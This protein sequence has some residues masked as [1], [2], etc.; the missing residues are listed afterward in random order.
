MG[1]FYTNI[2]LRGASAETIKKQL[3]RMKRTAFVASALPDVTVV[4]DAQADEQDHEAIVFLASKLS[5]ELGCIA[6]SVL[7]HDDDILWYRLYD[8]GNLLD[9][10]DSTPG[11]FDPQAQPSAPAGGDASKLAEA[12]GCRTATQKIEAVLR[13]SSFDD[14]GYAFALYRHRDLAEALSLTFNLLAL[15]YNYIQCGDTPGIAPENFVRIDT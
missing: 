11:Y 1:N 12:F 10:Y 8:R 15:G 7:N 14:D 4:Y 2:V 3:E 13:K 6:W 5:R 9:E